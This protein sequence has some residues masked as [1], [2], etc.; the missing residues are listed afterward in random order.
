MPFEIDDTSLRSAI[1]QKVSSKMT[2]QTAWNTLMFCQTLVSP[3]TDIQRV[4]FSSLTE[5][6]MVTSACPWQGLVHPRI[7]TR[8]AKP[9]A[10]GVELGNQPRFP[11]EFFHSLF[12]CCATHRSPPP[13]NFA[14]HEGFN[15]KKKTT[16]AVAFFTAPQERHLCR[17]AKRRDRAMKGS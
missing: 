11:G 4:F 5:P 7:V 17:S 14:A 10:V 2:L 16:E 12:S 13:L 1:L 3:L 9:L 8:V 15:A 6:H